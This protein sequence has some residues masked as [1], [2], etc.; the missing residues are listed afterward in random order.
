[1]PYFLYLR[2]FSDSY[3]YLLPQ[4]FSPH[5]IL[6]HCLLPRPP[7]LTTAATP[8]CFPRSIFLFF[9]SFHSIRPTSSFLPSLSLP[10]SFHPRFF[11][12]FH[13]PIPR[14]FNVELT[15]FRCTWRETWSRR[16]FSWNIFFSPLHPSCPLFYSRISIYG[17]LAKRLFLF[18]SFRKQRPFI[19]IV[20]S[21]NERSTANASIGF[22][23]VAAWDRFKARHPTITSPDLIEFQT[24]SSPPFLRIN[25]CARNG[26][27]GKE[28]R[29]RPSIRILSVSRNSKRRS[30]LNRGS[31]SFLLLFSKKVCTSLYLMESYPSN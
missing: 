20:A 26:S 13:S 17:S 16:S 8:P 27:Q 24:G 30:S 4:F 15:L 29:L 23:D 5:R 2:F 3:I 1:M 11:F 18:I 22:F 12:V 7:L 6:F 19:E 9:A 10:L 21:L 14:R 28:I 25:S 31:F